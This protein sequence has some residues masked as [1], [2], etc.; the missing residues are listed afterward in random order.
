MTHPDHDHSHS[1]APVYHITINAE[2][3]TVHQA[4]LSFDEICHLA[5]PNGPFGGNIRYTVTYSLPDGRESS[6]VQG[7]TIEVVEGAVF[8]V[9]NTDRS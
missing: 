2:S 9:G 4:R 5:F 3:V 6:M 1:H 7:D 8:Y